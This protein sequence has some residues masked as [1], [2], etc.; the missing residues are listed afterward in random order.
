MLTPS[1]DREGVTPGGA[2][3]RF[4]WALLPVVLWR[5]LFCFENGFSASFFPFFLVHAAIF[6]SR[7]RSI[8]PLVSAA[9]RPADFACGRCYLLFSMRAYTGALSATDSTGRPETPLHRWGHTSLGTE[10]L[11]VRES[12][13]RDVLLKTVRN[14][15]VTSR[16]SRFLVPVALA[17]TFPTRASPHYPNIAQTAECGLGRPPSAPLRGPYHL[18]F[19]SLN[20]FSI[21][22]FATGKYEKRTCPVTRPVFRTVGCESMLF[23]R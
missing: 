14:R 10:R 5:A 11:H 9:F 17:R 3:S 22:R 16:L 1:H 15:R 21:R 6:A 20:A 18:L 23:N 13:G 4:G 19:S 12:S 7:R 8:R 2:F